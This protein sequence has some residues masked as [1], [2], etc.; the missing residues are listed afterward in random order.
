M[1]NCSSIRFIYSCGTRPPEM[2]CARQNGSTVTHIHVVVFRLGHSRLRLVEAHRSDQRLELF[3]RLF[4][5][6]YAE[7]RGRGRGEGKQNI[8][9]NSSV[10]VELLTYDK[11]ARGTCRKNKTNHKNEKKKENRKKDTWTN[12]R[13]NEWINKRIFVWKL[14]YSR[15]ERARNKAKQAMALKCANKKATT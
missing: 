10:I 12:E 15:Q 13:M 9:V 3:S 1:Y 11:G 14:N 2:G 8:K 4:V 6:Y 5:Y 7:R